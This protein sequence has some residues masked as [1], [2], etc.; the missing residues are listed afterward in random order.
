MGDGRGNGVAG[1]VGDTAGRR[2]VATL[3]QRVWAWASDDARKRVTARERHGDVVAVP[4]VRVGRTV[5]RTGDGRSRCV[6]VQRRAVGRRVS[7]V[8]PGNSLHELARAF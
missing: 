1:G 8:V 6:D 3:V 2:L 7:G 4:A 5:R